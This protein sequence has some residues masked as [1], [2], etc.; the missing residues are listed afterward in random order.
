MT[1]AELASVAD[2]TLDVLRDLAELQEQRSPKLSALVASV[3]NGRVEDV[4]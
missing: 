2:R 4:I 1:Q 3:A